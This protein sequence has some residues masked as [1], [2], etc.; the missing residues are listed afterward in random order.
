MDL[1]EDVTFLKMHQS[2]TMTVTVSND[3]ITFKMTGLHI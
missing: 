2:K 1:F 3:K